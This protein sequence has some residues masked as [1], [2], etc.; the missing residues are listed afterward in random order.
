MKCN[1]A[2]TTTY[3]DRNSINNLCAK[4]LK[5]QRSNFLRSP[6][7]TILKDLKF[8]DAGSVCLDTRM[9]LICYSIG[10]LVLIYY[11]RALVH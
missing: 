3:G 5:H 1:A 11:F 4:Q 10:V 6:N 9:P 2:S 8:G 7:F